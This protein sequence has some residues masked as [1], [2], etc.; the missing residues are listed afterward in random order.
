MNTRSNIRLTSYHYHLP[1]VSPLQTNKTT[2]SHREGMILEYHSP[3]DAFYG[4]AAPLPGFSMESLKDV[5][6]QINRHHREILDILSSQNPTENMQLFFDHHNI[7]PSLRFALDSLAY[8]LKACRHSQSLPS[9]LSTTYPPTELPVNALVSLDNDSLLHQVEKLVQNGFNTLKVK[10]GLDFDTEYKKLKQISSQFPD[11]ILRLDAN[12]AWLVDEAINNLKRL[13]ELDIEYCEEP[14]KYFNTQ[15]LQ[16]LSTNTKIPIAVDES[17]QQVNWK[18][19]PSFIDAVILKPMVLGDFATFYV[20]SHR[21]KSHEITT[22][23]TTSLESAIGRK[24][25]ALLASSIAVSDTAHGLNTGPYLA[26]D[27]FDD[28][29]CLDGGKYYFDQET[30]DNR[31]SLWKSIEKNYLQSLSINTHEYS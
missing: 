19:D 6:K 23:V 3:D 11:V 10:V 20:T 25:T 7:V 26:A 15:N 5:Q 27:V 14:L 2:F 4:E 1:F 17:L 30:V 8:Q 13:H 29:C 21:A 12:Q 16:L 28:Q 9:F 24:V 18:K 22:V 31:K